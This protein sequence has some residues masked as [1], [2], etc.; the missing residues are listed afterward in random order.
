[1]S[2]GQSSGRSRGQERSG[3]LGRSGGQGS[4]WGKSSYLFPCQSTGLYTSFKSRLQ[5]SVRSA[6]EQGTTVGGRPPLSA[7]EVHLLAS[8]KVLEAHMNVG[9]GPTSRFHAAEERDYFSL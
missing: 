2:G 1:M 7:M 9:V 5:Q 6:Q 4:L 3:G 8:P